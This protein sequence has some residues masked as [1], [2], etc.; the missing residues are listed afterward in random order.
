MIRIIIMMIIIFVNEKNEHSVKIKSLADRN[1]RPGP[2]HT[3]IVIITTGPRGK[4]FNIQYIMLKG[5]IHY[6]ASS[7]GRHGKSTAGV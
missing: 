5:S 7:T 3:Y 6:N 2:R 1:S 4:P